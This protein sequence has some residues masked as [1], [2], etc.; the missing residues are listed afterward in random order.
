[1]LAD[2]PQEKTSTDPSQSEPE[3]FLLEVFSLEKIKT[4]TELFNDSEIENLVMNYIRKTSADKELNA[5]ICR[6]KGNMLLVMAT[7]K[8]CEQ[9]AAFLEKLEATAEKQPE[10]RKEYGNFVE[11]E[12]PTFNEGSVARDQVTYHPPTSLGLNQSNSPQTTFAVKFQHQDPAEFFELFHT[13]G[14]TVGENSPGFKNILKLDTSSGI[15]IV[16][17][18]EAEVEQMRHIIA[19]YDMVPPKD[20]D[21]QLQKRMEQHDSTQIITFKFKHRP[22]EPVAHFLNAFFSKIPIN[23][24]EPAPMMVEEFIFVSEENMLIVAS[25]FDMKTTVEFVEQLKPFLQ[26][27]D[28]PQALPA[29]TYQPVQKNDAPPVFENA[30]QKPETPRPIL[31]QELPRAQ[32]IEMLQPSQP[33]VPQQQTYPQLSPYQPEL[34]Q[35]AFPQMPQQYPPPGQQAGTV[36][37]PHYLQVDDS[38]T[39]HVIAVPFVNRKAKDFLD[40]LML[41]EDF[42]AIGERMFVDERSNTFIFTGISSAPDREAYIRNFCRAFDKP[43]LLGQFPDLESFMAQT[44]S[45]AV[46]TYPLTHRSAKE[47]CHFARAGLQTME[48][49]MTPK[50]DENELKVMLFTTAFFTDESDKVLI[51]A[52]NASS[53]SMYYDSEHLKKCLAKYDVP[54]TIGEVLEPTGQPIAQAF[55]LQNRNPAEFAMLLKNFAITAGELDKESVGFAV[56]FDASTQTVVVL[57]QSDNFIEEITNMVPFYDAK[58]GAS[59]YEYASLSDFLAK[60]PGAIAKSF[61]VKNIPAESVCHFWR[62]FYASAKQQD[63]VGVIKIAFFVDEKS[64]KLM[65]ASIDDGIFQA[66]AKFVELCNQEQ[67]LGEWIQTSLPVAVQPKE[68]KPTAE[69]VPIYK[70][71]F[72]GDLVTSPNGEAD[73]DELIKLIREVIDPTGWADDASEDAK[74]NT[75]QTFHGSKTLSIKAP[76][77]I[78]DQI[79]DLLQQLRELPPNTDPQEEEK[80]MTLPE[81]FR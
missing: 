2:D 62:C 57:Y 25:S 69:T 31:V 8:Q 73:Y 28:Q 66:I 16:S 65:V 34:Q 72:V 52:R 11:Y 46:E 64:Q 21:D 40:L 5:P 80:P 51:V 24:P 7:A 68:P 77:E 63:S 47:L 37:Q 14:N 9:I 59:N 56:H 26:T 60:H 19:R 10:G 32:P 55:R 67:P 22:T 70:Q 42:S 71:Y 17:G 58:S 81:W 74:G 15:L 45:V 49:I 1:M 27:W 79:V 29:S 4:A 12:V 48:I 78:H 13:L 36:P 33:P 43:E 35:Q 18:P 30:L 54:Q 3:E 41:D 38:Q 20:L 50:I 53:N 61:Q 6:E 23:P 75:I 76:P 44:E 39:S